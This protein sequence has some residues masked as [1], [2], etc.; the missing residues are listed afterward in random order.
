MKRL[1]AATLSLALLATAV[2]PAMAA[3]YGAGGRDD[4]HGQK[5]RHDD[6]RDPPRRGH[7]LAHDHRGE[8]VRDYRHHGLHAPARGQEWRKVD[9]RYVLVAVATGIIADVVLARR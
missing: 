6:R 3:P 8:Y 7:R 2:S 5:D 4:H 1:I 9:G